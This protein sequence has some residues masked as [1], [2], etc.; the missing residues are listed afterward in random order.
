MKAQALRT[1]EDI[2]CAAV[3]T[4]NDEGSTGSLLVRSIAPRAAS[5]CR[6]A[7]GSPATTIFE[8]SALMQVRQYEI[9]KLEHGCCRNAT[10]IQRRGKGILVAY[11]LLEWLSGPGPW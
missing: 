11:L 6:D 1:A 8:P 4:A 10:H 5:G 2:A 9:Y 7:R 3:P